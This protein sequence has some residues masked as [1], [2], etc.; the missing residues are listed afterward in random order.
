MYQKVMQSNPTVRNLKLL[1]STLVYN[2][3]RA[4]TKQLFLPD[5]ITS[6]VQEYFH[7]CIMSVHLGVSKTPSHTG[8]VF[9]QPDMG[10]DACNFV[11]QC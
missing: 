11:R 6:M 9:Y 4:K 1:D 5:T 3:S 8:K 2:P 7:N 10:T